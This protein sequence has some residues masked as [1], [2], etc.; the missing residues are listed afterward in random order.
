MSHRNIA[1]TYIYIYQHLDVYL[2]FTVLDYLVYC[3]LIPNVRNLHSSW[4]IQPLD[5]TFFVNDAGSMFF[6]S[7]NLDLFGLISCFEDQSVFLKF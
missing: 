7:E 1:L 3:K 6:E 2:K 4:V 5:K